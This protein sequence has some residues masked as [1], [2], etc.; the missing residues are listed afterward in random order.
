MGRDEG[1][2][3]GPHDLPRRVSRGGDHAGAL[4]QA[5]QH[6]WAVACLSSAPP[7]L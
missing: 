6:K 5:E 3:V 1:G 2:V 4:A 7:W